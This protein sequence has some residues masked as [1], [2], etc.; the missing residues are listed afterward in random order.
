VNVVHAKANSG[1]TWSLSSITVDETLKQNTTNL[2]LKYW[3]PHAGLTACDREL[4]DA[5][6]LEAEYGRLGKKNCKVR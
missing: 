4:G 2:H 1:Q 6:L 5:T 3:T